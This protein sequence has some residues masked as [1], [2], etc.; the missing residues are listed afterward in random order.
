MDTLLA[1]LP[2][3]II[4]VLMAWLRWGG[5][6]AG[7]AGWLAALVIAAL[8][9][10]VTPQALW[11]AQV[12]GITRAAYVL[13][14][15]WGALLFFRVTEADGTLKAMSDLLQQLSPGRMLQVLLLAWAFASFLQGVGGYGVPVAVVAPIMVT[16][17]FPP[18][19]A[20]VMP[21]M[22]QSWAVSF[23]SLG[24]SFEALT[25]AT[26]LEASFIAPWMAA[27]L[28][29]VC[30]L[31]GLAVLWVAGG[32]T[33]LRSEAWPL[34]T[35][36]L[37]MSLAQYA[38]V[39]AD[40][41]NI[42]ALI[43]ALAGLLTGG[44]WA[45]WRRR[46]VPTHEITPIPIKQTAV[47]MLPY[48]ILIGIILAVNFIPLLDTLLNRWTLSVDVP[49]LTLHDGTQ[50]PAD[51]TKSISVLGHPGAQLIY[52]ALAALLIARLRGTLPP[53][54]AAKIRKGVVGSGTKSSLGIMAMMAMAT[55]MQMAGMV[56]ELAEAMAALAGRFFPV[57]S[58]FIGALGAFMT[59]SNTNS[60]VLLGAFQLQVARTLA[61]HV[62]LVIALHNAG[63]AVGSVFGP[64]KII[65]GCS[66]VGLSGQES[67]ALRQT[68]RYGLTIV[69]VVAVLG[70][71]IARLMPAA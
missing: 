12:Q 5:A 55:T 35:M 13:Y 11:W 60:N 68:S 23:G 17:G 40:L 67:G 21:S 6:Q 50:I 30:L 62:P 71:V 4:L 26:G 52:A 2:L 37:A 56:S 34:V 18:L 3:I 66:T 19:E 29:V 1:A 42:G 7:A 27:I 32:K 58:P 43:G 39:A 25:S 36:A 28:T 15:I 44:V 70:F 57:I 54:S 9:F 64:A 8:R 31:A 47:R 41:A 48:A 65:V 61:L 16:M 59:G 49:A 53:G 22:G 24:A 69:A 20:V 51:R 10:G 33:A 63:A 38:A 46:R 45:V 14:I